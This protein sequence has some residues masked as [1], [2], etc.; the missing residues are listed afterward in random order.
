MKTS[1][2]II[3]TFVSLLATAGMAL[4]APDSPVGT[5]LTSVVDFSSEYPFA[6]HFKQAR[7]WIS[8]NTRTA[9]FDDGRLFNLDANGDITSLKANQVARTV[10]FTGLPADPTLKG[11]RMIVRYDGDGRLEYNGQVTVLSRRAGRDVIE[12]RGGSEVDE[13]IVIIN[14]V[15]TNPAN[16]VRRIRMTPTGGIS[17]S[18]PLKAVVSAAA[19]PAGDFISFEQAASQDE[20]IFNPVF[21]NSIKGFRSIRFMDWLHTNNSPQVNFSDRARLSHQFWSTDAGVPLEAIIELSN[22]MNLDPWLNIPHLATDSYVRQF[23][24]LLRNRLNPSLRACIEYSNETW[25][26]IF[27]QTE[28]VENKGLELGLDAPRNNRFIG[29]LRFYSQRSQRIFDIF[30][31]VYG[32]ERAAR[33]RRVMASQSAN[34]FTTQTVLSF[35]NAA[36]KTDAFAIAPYFGETVIDEIKAAEIKRLGVNGIFDWLQNDNNAILERSLPFVDREVAAQKAAVKQFRIPLITYEGGQHFVGAFGFENDDELNVIMDALNKD[37]RMKGIYLTYLNNW[38]KRSN[39][40]FW[41]FVSVERHSKFG[42]WGSREFAQE[43]R[44]QAP[45]FDAIQTYIS[46]RPLP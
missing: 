31:N 44:S 6:D 7:P 30:N 4:S 8:G 16:P 34:P 46:Q 3:A 19:V 27:T 1:K 10:M 32:S 39:E 14:L 21:L 20:I 26:G 33:I 11:K 40:V 29:G 37:P 25:N 28:F 36:K 9:A 23:A 45:K 22:L 42:R 41:H 15:R 38:R 43:T 13:A 18:N 5:N 17:R 24:T 12:L 35:T 2:G